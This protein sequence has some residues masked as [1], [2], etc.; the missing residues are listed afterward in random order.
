MFQNKM[1]LRLRIFISMILLVFTATL[2]VLGSTY[3][4]YRTE[5]DQ[6]NSYR[7]ERKENQLKRQI[8]YI[9]NK[10]DLSE[11]YDLWQEYQ[12]DFE[13]ITRIHNVEYSI[14]KSDGTPLFYSYLPLD[15]ISNNYS[16][17]VDF[18][19]MIAT[20]EDGKF[21]SENFTD[22]GKFQS[23]YS[24]LKDD[25]GT[26]YAILFFPYFQDV[27]FAESELN[28]FL[29]TLYQIYFIMLVVAIVL[30]YFISR[31]VTRS[32]ETIRLKIGQAGLLKKNEKIYLKN[33]TKEIDSLVNS[34]NKMI[35]D[36]EDSAERLAKTEREQAWQEMAKQV[37]HEIKNPLTPMRLTVQSFQKNSGV[38]SNNEKNKIN[39]FC[40]TLIEQIDTMSNVA[41]SFSDF[42]TLPKTQLEKTD[43]VE[44][45]KKAV[46][47]FEQNNIT[48]VT[49][50][51]S[52]FV[53]L[54]KEQWIRVMTNLIK[55]SIQAIPH[56]RDPD[57]LVQISESSKSVKI[58]VSDN[59]QGVSKINRDKI[60]EPKFTTKSDGMGLGLGIVRNIISSHRGKISYKSKRNKGTNFTISLPK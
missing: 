48:F 33:A 55:N 34:Y 46:E 2:L 53:K 50:S 32:I 36:L 24:M 56:E 29:S 35:D 44:A 51:N 60:F 22:V 31:F 13:E 17:D 11:N 7:Q 8:N 30:A 21:I 58:L 6:Y 54:D 12:S 39:D 59:G 41:T 43:I 45:T 3:Y 16:L 57:I 42:A 49:S 37:A 47:I 5:S 28:V 26:N 20:N 4:Q 19:K 15:V 40:Q 9:V 14:F 25:L 23:S 38:N 10:Y 1:S 27:S 52:I 18:A